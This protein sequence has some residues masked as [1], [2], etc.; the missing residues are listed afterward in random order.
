MSQAYHV[1]PSE[2]LAI[3]ANDPRAYHTDRAVW[4]Y[5][6]C[7]EEDM[8]AAESALD[9]K[10]VTAVDIRRARQSVFD[11][12]MSNDASQTTTAPPKGRFADPAVRF[13]QQGG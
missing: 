2:L 11:A 3:P 1:R 8:D 6:S 7:V 4:Y 10:R 9:P 13:K 5:A 12:Y